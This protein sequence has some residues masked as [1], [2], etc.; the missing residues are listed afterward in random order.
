MNKITLKVLFHQ[1]RGCIP[2]AT[3][4]DIILSYGVSISNPKSLEKAL[5]FESSDAGFNLRLYLYRVEKSAY[6][7]M[8]EGEANQN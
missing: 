6:A 1:P 8:L 4:F 2:G 5:R 3:I 7:M